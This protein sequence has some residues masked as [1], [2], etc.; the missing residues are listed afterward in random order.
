M[1]PRPSSGSV[2]TEQYY[3]YVLASEQVLWGVVPFSKRIYSHVG[4]FKWKCS[5]RF[6]MGGLGA[7]GKYMS[8]DTPKILQILKKYD[9][10]C[11]PVFYKEYPILKCCT[12]LVSA[13]NESSKV[14]TAT[15]SQIPPNAPISM[16]NRRRFAIP[17]LAGG[18]AKLL[19]SPALKFGLTHQKCISIQDKF[20]WDYLGNYREIIF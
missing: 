5:G 15:A 18:Y 9:W 10:A 19:Y 14:N 2:P 7:W 13:R 4:F 3:V 1:A 12:P 6:N 20:S 8:S 17:F 16:S 11:R